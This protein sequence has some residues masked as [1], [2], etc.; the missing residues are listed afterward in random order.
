MKHK[1]AMTLGAITLSAAGLIGSAS[2]AGAAA[3]PQASGS[4]ETGIQAGRFHFFK[5]DNFNGAHASIGGTDK[6]LTNNTW[7]GGTVHNGT[8][9]VQNQSSHTVTLWDRPSSCS[10]E[11]YKSGPGDQDKD[12]SNNRFDNK[13]S[14]AKFS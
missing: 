14:C 4:S 6:N 12:L 8:S 7:A 2:T 10:G 13:A 5:H 9:S 11:K 3:E 1:L